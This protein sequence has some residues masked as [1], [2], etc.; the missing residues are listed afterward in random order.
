MFNQIDFLELLIIYSLA[1]NNQKNTDDVIDLLHFEI[2]SRFVIVEH[3]FIN[4]YFFRYHKI[5]F[6]G[7]SSN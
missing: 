1:P 4:S 3:I 6:R 5:S 2:Q 7:W